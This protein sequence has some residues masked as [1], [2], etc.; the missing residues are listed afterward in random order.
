MDK[1]FS[2]GFMQYIA[3]LLE[4]CNEHHTDN[5][6]LLFT[7]GDKKLSMDITFSTEQD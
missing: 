4:Y 6:A 3:D 1:I 7:V 5:I 2:D